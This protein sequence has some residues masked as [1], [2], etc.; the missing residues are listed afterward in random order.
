[1]DEVNRHFVM[2]CERFHVVGAYGQ[3]TTW[4]GEV[5]E[6]HRRDIMRASV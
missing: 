4:Y 2:V 5:L 6:E 1:M 3:T